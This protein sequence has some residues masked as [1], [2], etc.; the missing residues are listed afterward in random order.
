MSKYQPKVELMAID[1]IKPYDKNAKVHT[2][3]QIASLVKVIQS[4]GWDVPIVV[5]KDGV[6]IKGHGRRLAALSMG[7]TEVPVIVRRDL[8]DAQ[9]KAARLSDNRV[10]MGDFDVDAIKDELSALKSD[11]FDLSNMGFDEKEVNMMLGDLDSLDFDA[12]EG[13]SKTQPEALQATPDST[14]TPES[15]SAEEAPKVKAMLLADV[16]GFKHIPGEYKD[17]LVEFLSQAET[18]TGEQGAEAFC[19]LIRAILGGMTS[20]DQGK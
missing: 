12:F 9:V 18:Q 4:Q 13:S 15:E 16:L 5:D 11:G 3:S 1:K 7:L 17:D 19:K 8:T 14:A 2:E 10:A 6:I 20:E